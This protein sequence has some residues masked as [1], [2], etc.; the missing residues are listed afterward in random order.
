MDVVDILKLSTDWAKAE[1][2]SAKM[3]G[4]YSLFIFL[5]AVGFW[6]LGKTVMARAFVI[7][8]IVM[9][10]LMLTVAAGLYLTN[11]PRIVRFQKE[12]NNDTDA[13][14][15]KE[16]QRT[17]KSQAELGVVFKVLPAIIIVAA[18]LIIFVP[19][20]QWRA[21]GITIILLMASLMVVDSNTDARNT[22]Y[23]RN[24]LKSKPDH[25]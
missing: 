7:P 18:L 13:F 1:I 9:A 24:L 23:H 25:S 2:F 17:A 4:L 11:K 20:L 6:Q 8:L 22:A 10:M 15:Q 14:L 5:L 12:V 16:V 21:I 3:V 19:S